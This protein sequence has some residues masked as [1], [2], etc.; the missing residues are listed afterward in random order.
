MYIDNPPECPNCSYRLS[1]TD[2]DNLSTM[3]RE[4]EVFEVYCP[5]C[6]ENFNAICTLET[7]TIAT[8]SVYDP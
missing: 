6:G 5:K 2:I 8:V 7:T 4:G 1:S 3:Y